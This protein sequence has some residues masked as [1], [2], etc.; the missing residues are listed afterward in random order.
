MNRLPF[1]PKV[2]PGT[3][4]EYLHPPYR[5]SLK[6]APTK[7]LIFL[8]SA[9]SERSGPVF[10]HAVVSANDNDLTAQH[11]GSPAGERIV[12]SGRLLDEDGRA[13]PGALVE[14]WQ[15]N[16]AGRYRHQLD[17]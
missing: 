5:S 6:R 12:V 1:F 17:Q 2:P 9:L 15:A 11:E 7:P 4:P 3:Q 14:V 13:V 8:P 10:G 16:A